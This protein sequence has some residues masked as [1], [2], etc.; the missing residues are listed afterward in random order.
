MLY[1]KYAGALIG[2]T[3]MSKMKTSKDMDLNVYRFNKATE[4]SIT[5][6]GF[7]KKLLNMCHFMLR[8]IIKEKEHKQAN[9]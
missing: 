8:F 4:A 5:R 3:F 6:V 2:T 1:P 7:A 9:Q